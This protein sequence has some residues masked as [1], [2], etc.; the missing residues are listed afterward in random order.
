VRV[1]LTNQY[2]DLPLEIGA[3]TL[4]IREMGA[5]IRPETERTLSL[6]GLPFVTIQAGATATS[7]AVTLAVPALSDL[8]ITLY[9]PNPTVPTTSHPQAATGYLSGSGDFTQASDGAPFRMTMR[10]WFFL[11]SVDVLAP[12][13][14]GAIVALG[15]STWRRTPRRSASSA[16][17]CPAR[18]AQQSRS[19]RTG[20]AS[21][22]SD[23]R[24]YS[25]FMVGRSRPA[26]RVARPVRAAPHQR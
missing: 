26:P 16:R 25:R 4:G 10:Q 23:G 18:T 6:D 22:R 3:S 20:A 8:A 19:R 21:S 9:L 24:G 17:Y 11:D 7:D 1:K 14:A 2:G 13:H 5:S 15:D 12:G